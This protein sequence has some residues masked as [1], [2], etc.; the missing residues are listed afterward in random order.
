MESAEKVYRSQQRE[1]VLREALPKTWK[2]LIDEPDDSLVDLIIEN[3]E[4]QCGF[5]PDVDDI[6]KFL[7]SERKFQTGTNENL[8]KSTPSSMANIT[9]RRRPTSTLK[10]SYI[11]T[12]C[13]SFLFLGKKYYPQTWQELLN[14]VAKQLYDAHRSEFDRC[15]SLRGS[16]MIYFSKDKNVL[17]YPKHISASDYYFEA[18]LSAN[19]IVR[20]AKELM[21]LFGHNDSDLEI[22]IK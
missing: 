4:R 13:E 21:G 11:N 3:T 15:L 12:K 2:K 14:I 8:K 9:Q 6:V 22:T 17:S 10:E 1:T 5:R 20:R 7:Q 18:K 19:S 16:R